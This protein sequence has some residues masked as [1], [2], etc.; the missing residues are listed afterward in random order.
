MSNLTWIVLLIPAFPLL[1]FLLN[2]FVIR[3]ERTAGLLASTM[4]GLAFLATLLASA[5]LAQQPEGQRILVNLYS[6][7]SIG[8]F[9][10]SVG[11]L[12]DQLTVVMALLVTGV[13]T[14]IHVYSIGYIHGDSRAV[15][16]FAYLNLFIFMML[17]LIMANNMLLLF[18]GWE[19]VGLA[20][21]LL[22]GFW[23]ERKSVEPGIVPAGAAI[24]AFVMNRV[25]DAGVIL[26]MLLLFTHFGTLAFY[27][28]GNGFLEKLASY[29]GNID[30]GAFGSMSVVGIIGLLLFVG[31][32]G[33]SAQLPLFT[34]LP[35][36]MA[37]PTPVSALIHAATMVTSG[38]Y[39][40][41][42]NRTL[43]SSIG[44]LDSWVP[45]M[46]VAFGLFTVLIGAVSAIAQWDIKRVLAYST[47]SQL[48][49]MVVAAGMGATTTAMFHLLTHGFFKALLF[50]AAGS[51]IH[52][53]HD[54]QDMRHMG[55][56][57]TKLPLTFR[58][59]AV[60]GL[61]LAGIFPFAGFWS[62]DEIIAAAWFGTAETGHVGNPTLAVFLIIAA[63]LTAFYVGRQLA[64]IFW[65]TQRDTSY[66]PHES[67]S[68][69]TTPLIILAV[70]TVLGGAINMPG[71]APLHH[72]LEPVLGEAAE[73][74]TLGNGILA[75]VTLLLS[76]G[77]LFGG[78]WLYAR[79]DWA[80]RIRLGKTDPL[81]HYTGDIWT[82]AE[83]GIGIDWLY[84]YVFARPYN[85][86]SAWVGEV[87][88]QQGIQGVLVEGLGKLVG[89]LS[90]GFRSLQSGMIRNYVLVFFGGVVLLL[91]YFVLR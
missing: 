74:Y 86:F 60:G 30:M 62:K 35:D 80:A 42:R 64:L 53:T 47:V 78:W 36:A 54:I 40:M 55:G 56:L 58:A 82:A 21:F 12:F 88:D 10:V 32:T 59:F 5:V 9:S 17:V 83:H 71:L 34:W 29:G 2:T 45:G 22:I 87:F 49:Y 14:L 6:W 68:L 33:K 25:G 13:G 89:A 8:D 19:G 7:F 4:T 43:F 75:V 84:S 44:T 46:I 81:Y 90:R 26:A 67:G 37:G 85:G 66:H 20:S 63:M 16:F 23:F 41:A 39:L 50:L 79:S 76:A 38:V 18:L 70:L 1:G 3:E 61:A 31:V 15:R 28:G 57:R 69:M 11:V 52:A 24:K 27:D 48:G 73:E 51:V 77:S 65:G 91:G 72:Y